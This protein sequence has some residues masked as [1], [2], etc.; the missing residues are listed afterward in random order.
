DAWMPTPERICMEMILDAEAANP[1]AHALNY[2][3]AEHASG[4]MVMLRDEISGE[5]FAVKPK[6]V[7]N[8]AGPWIDFAND[9]LGRRTQFIGGTKGSHLIVDHQE[10][11]DVT[12]GHEL[13]FENKDGRICLFFP[14]HDKV[15]VGTTDIRIDDPEQ[16]RCTDDEIDYLLES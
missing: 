8:A 11:H 2:V 15:I 9:A 6:I 5:S 12:D 7:I 16:A 4:D 14:L 10:L 13:F 3:R 1:Q